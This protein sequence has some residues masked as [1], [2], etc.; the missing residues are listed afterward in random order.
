MLEVAE[1]DMV[2]QPRVPCTVR[3]NF[4]TRVAKFFWKTWSTR[5]QVWVCQRVTLTMGRRH[6][7]LDDQLHSC[8]HWSPRIVN[9]TIHFRKAIHHDHTHLDA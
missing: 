1:R 8:V 4:A 6:L 7:G 5:K 3:K 9:H 2:L